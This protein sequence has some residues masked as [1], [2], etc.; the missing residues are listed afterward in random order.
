[1]AP[2]EGKPFLQIL[3][4]YLRAQG[5]GE[6]V[7]AVSYKYEAIR[8]YFGTEFEGLRL[9]YSIEEEPLGTGGGL[10][11]ALN[12][13]T[14]E[15]L[16]VLNGD[17]YFD[18]ALKDLT[19]QGGEI[20]LA[21]KKMREFE[22]YGA[23]SLGEGGEI[24]EF[25]EKCFRAEGLINGGVYRLS[26]RIFEGFFLEENFS[27]EEFLQANFKTLK[28]RARVFEGF[29]ADI[30]IPQDYERFIKARAFAKKATSAQ[31]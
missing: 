24:L 5:V 19:L 26:R 2:V 13:C 16:F 28:A 4:E 8:D 30:G 1:M 21:L 29:F 20:C 25:K 27:F 9:Q 7:L 10:K 11:K 23:V 15:E 17:S 6:V 14:Q 3:L 18:I 12:L 31:G 22:R